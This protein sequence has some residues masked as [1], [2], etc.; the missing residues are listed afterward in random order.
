[1]GDSSGDGVARRPGPR[2]RPFHQVVVRHQGAVGAH[3]RVQKQ[4][5]PLV[6]FKA[7]ASRLFP[8]RQRLPESFLI[9]G[10]Q[11]IR[12]VGFRF[13]NA[14]RFGT[15]RAVQPFNPFSPLTPG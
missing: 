6:T 3:R 12:P 13:L 15:I 8:T 1:M 4:I 5:L 7:K 10:P 2:S 11:M 9:A 14:E